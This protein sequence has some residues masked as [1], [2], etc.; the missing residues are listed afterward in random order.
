MKRL[1]LFVTVGLLLGSCSEKYVAHSAID[2]GFDARRTYTVAIMPLFVRGP[3][4][5]PGAFERDR[6]YGFLLRR[7]METG[8]L[9]PM[10]KPA[11]DRAVGLQEFGQQGMVSPVKA[12][13]IGKEL[14]AQLVCLAEV[15]IE[16]ESVI[17]ATV[18]I[19]DVSS[20]TTAYSGSAKATAALSTVAAAESALKQ[21]TEKLVQ[22]MK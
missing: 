15:N 21:A 17:S 19:L 14:G 16:Q 2:P 8:K 3:A 13:E 18:D 7:L 12:R 22:K 20:T 9:R 6:A 10:D 5:T 11:V 1:A 4:V